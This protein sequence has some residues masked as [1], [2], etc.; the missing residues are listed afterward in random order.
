MHASRYTSRLGTV[1]ALLALTAALAGCNVAPDT[2]AGASAPAAPED[3][4][5]GAVPT[6][7]FVPVQ[8]L[9]PPQFESISPPASAAEPEPA[10]PS[11]AA[12]AP[13]ASD[14]VAAPPAGGV[15]PAPAP[16]PTPSLIVAGAQTVRLDDDAWYGGWKQSKTYGG[17][18]ATWI[19]GTGTPYSTM[20]ATFELAGQPAGDAVL[21]IEGMDGEN[22]PK[23]Q[24]SILVNGAELWRGANPLPDDDYS[25]DTGNWATYSWNIPAAFLR[26][27]ANTITIV[28]LSE[29]SVGQPPFMMLDYADLTIGG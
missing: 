24:I 28:A 19:Y 6:P 20:A 14:P 29:G 7:T 22:A 16:Q 25:L 12:A 23:M 9:Q 10:P 5:A 15:A 11:D 1:P 4:L 17:R 2:Q 21:S 8:G 13:A 18:S 3:E 27:G 26:P